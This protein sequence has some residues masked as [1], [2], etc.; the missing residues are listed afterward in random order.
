MFATDNLSPAVLF[1][2]NLILGIAAAGI[3]TS[4]VVKMVYRS[5]FVRPNFKG[6]PIPVGVGFIFLLTALIALTVDYL[7]LPGLLGNR[8][9]IFI[10]GLSVITFLGFVDDTL[11]NR[12]ASGL[13]GHFK[14]LLKGELT[15]GGL[16]ALGGGVLALL[17]TLIDYRGKFGLDVSIINIIVSTL[18]IA[19]SINAVNLLDLRPG[20]AGKGFL[21]LAVVIIILSWGSYDILPLALITGSLLIYLPWDLKAKTMMGDTGSNALGLTIGVTAAW[22]FD[23]AAKLIYLGFL[24]FFHLFTEKYSLTKVIAGNKILNYLDKLGRE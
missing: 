24:I 9:T 3:V 10:L 5:E 8:G 11:G 12:Q 20:R 16:K 2:L 19:L 6:D 17:I 23:S 22:S 13:K 7:L 14:A 15:T 1:L 4:P 21:L 18:I